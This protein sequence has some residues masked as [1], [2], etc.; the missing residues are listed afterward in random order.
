MDIFQKTLDTAFFTISIFIGGLILK[1]PVFLFAETNIALTLFENELFFFFG[2]FIIHLFL[3]SIHFSFITYPLFMSILFF[4]TGWILYIFTPL[5]FAIISIF[6]DTIGGL[7]SAF[8]GGNF[9]F[10]FLDYIYKFYEHIAL[11]LIAIGGVFW[12]FVKKGVEITR[13]GTAIYIF[14]FIATSGIS[15][16]TGTLTTLFYSLIILFF[17]FQSLKRFSFFK[18]NSN[19]IRI[20]FRIV[21]TLLVIVNIVSTSSIQNVLA[22][23]NIFTAIWIKGLLFLLIIFVWLPRKAIKAI[24]EKIFFFNFLKTNSRWLIIGR[25]N[26]K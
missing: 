12:W 24:I 8:T 7:A 13:K 3:N 14:M 16:I 15:I 22:S 21:T 23:T 26:K 6:A 17:T 1:L 10:S 5:Y 18:L 20:A 25:K 9:Q 11:F 19:I 4:L 2:L